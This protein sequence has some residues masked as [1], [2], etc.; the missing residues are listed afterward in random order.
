[1]IVFYLFCLS[2]HILPIYDWLSK[3]EPTNQLFETFIF[4]D[5]SIFGL[6]YL[7]L[8][9]KYAEY[10]YFCGIVFTGLL[11]KSP[12]KLLQCS[13]HGY[14][15]WAVSFSH[16]LFY[17]IFSSCIIYCLLVREMSESDR[18]L[19]VH[20]HI[21]NTSKREWIIVIIYILVLC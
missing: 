18:V 20:V 6:F 19:E 4:I 1:M 17:I 11:P 14:V 15:F 12:W 2:I 16:E 7:G 8:G 3:H 10:F 13:H 21:S 9:R 5:Q